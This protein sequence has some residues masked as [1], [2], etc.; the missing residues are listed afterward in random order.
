MRAEDNDIRSKT[1][2][3]GERVTKDLLV[4]FYYLHKTLFQDSVGVKKKSS[5]GL[6]GGG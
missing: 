2:E 1:G 3:L 6:K 4:T 5:V